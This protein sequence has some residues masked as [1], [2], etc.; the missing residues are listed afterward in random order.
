MNKLWSVL[1]ICLLLATGCASTLEPTAIPV[2]GNPPNQPIA[3]A[4]AATPTVPLKPSGN[5]QSRLLGRVLDAN[6][7]LVKGATIEL[8]GSF[9]GA[10]P[11]AVS[12]D[13]GLYGFAGLC[14][15]SSGFVVTAPG[16]RA[17]NLSQPVTVDGANV[18]KADLTVKS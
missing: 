9:R 18:G 14:A 5:C 15:G 1:A 4:A 11:K 12:D 3:P 6:G 17:V 2:V 8:R 16:K 10:P 13:N 7:A